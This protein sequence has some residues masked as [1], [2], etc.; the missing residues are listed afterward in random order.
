MAALSSLLTY[1]NN[2]LAPSVQD[3][4]AAIQEP[5]SR[6]I[7]KRIED[8]EDVPSKTRAKQSEII[9]FLK[10]VDTE[11]KRTGK[12]MESAASSWLRTTRRCLQYS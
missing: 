1:G 6:E 2:A 10:L 11:K 5:E 4:I 9:K 7:R 12:G 3:S 8:V